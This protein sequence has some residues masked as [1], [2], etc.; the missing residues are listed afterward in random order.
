MEEGDAKYTIESESAMDSLSS[1]FWAKVVNVIF[2]LKICIISINRL[3]EK[4]HKK[5]IF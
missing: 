5:N 2:I 3:K 4:F 1:I